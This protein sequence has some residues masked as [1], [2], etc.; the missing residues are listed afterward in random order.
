MPGIDLQVVTTVR[1]VSKNE[2]HRRYIQLVAVRKRPI[3]NRWRFRPSSAPRCLIFSRC[4][5]WCCFDAY[6]LMIFDPGL[7]A[8][9]ATLR[10]VADRRI[11]TETAHAAVNA[12][13]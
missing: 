13:Y 1:F 12:H 6:K 9:E 4:K 11:V 10:I 7:T 8:Q 5:N 2:R 3:W